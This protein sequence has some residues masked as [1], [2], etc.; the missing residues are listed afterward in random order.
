MIVNSPLYNGGKEKL[1]QLHI[2]VQAVGQQWN[3][4]VKRK[5]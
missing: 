3:L 1:C 4:T 2:S 5:S